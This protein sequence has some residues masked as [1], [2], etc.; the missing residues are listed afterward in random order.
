MWNDYELQRAAN[1]WIIRTRIKVK[2]E[3][4]SYQ[5]HVARSHAEMVEIV[6]AIT[7]QSVAP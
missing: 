7:P 1:G 4:D 3:P 5:I 6:T 2:G